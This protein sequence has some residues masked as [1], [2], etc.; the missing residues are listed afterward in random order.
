M[1]LFGIRQDGKIVVAVPS[2]ESAGS[3]GG[4]RVASYPGGT[5]IIVSN[6]DNG[7]AGRRYCF[8]DYDW[9]EGNGLAS[10][11]M[12]HHSNITNLRA[13]GD[14]ILIVRSEYYGFP[15]GSLKPPIHRRLHNSH[16]RTGV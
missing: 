14:P 5:A 7:D 16:R 3:G 6:P 10:C 12:T 2:R 1:M 11:D 4:R 9:F 13:L 8:D 15:A